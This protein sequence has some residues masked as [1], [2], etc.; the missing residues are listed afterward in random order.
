L[1]FTLQQR[2]GANLFEPFRPGTLKREL[3]PDVRTK[4]AFGSANTRQQSAAM[5]RLLLSVL[6]CCV[7]SASAADPFAGQEYHKP[8]VNPTDDPK[9]P[10]V[11]LIGDSISIAYTTTV[12]RKLK[13]K[14]NVHRIK[15]NGAFS[16][17]G[18]ESVKEWIGDGR[19]DVI[20]FNFGLW[21]WYGW[22]QEQRATPEFY[23]KNLE[24]ITK[25]LKTTGASLIFATTTPP[26]DEAE[27]KIKVLVSEKQANAFNG[28]ATKVMKANGVAVNDLYECISADRKK[29]TKGPADVHWNQ[30][31][32]ELLGRQVA[33]EIAKALP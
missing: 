10:R 18:V 21:D 8:F 13:G 27:H 31:G 12:R 16:A 1:E 9:L 30:K 28:A 29:Y 19:W 15:T 5:K 2:V 20:H 3:Q 17:R 26:C 23:A 7:F 6:S 4:S 11:L 33:W 25:V 24:Q 32:S 22:R 14:A